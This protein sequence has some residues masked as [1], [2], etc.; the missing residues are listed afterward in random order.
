MIENSTHQNIDPSVTRVRHKRKPRNDT[1]VAMKKP[2]PVAEADIAGKPAPVVEKDIAKRP[3]PVAKANGTKSSQG[4]KNR[5]KKSLF[6]TIAL[7]LAVVFFV[8]AVVGAWFFWWTTQATFDYTLRP[9]VVLA[10][11][12][13]HPYDFM[14]EADYM[15]NISATYQMQSGTSS[16]LQ[17][18]SG[19]HEIPITLQLGLRSV[20]TTATLYVLEPIESIFHEFATKAEHMQPI[21]FIANAHI[22][23]G[24]GFDVTFTQT[25]L[26]LEHYSVGEHNLELALNG[27]PFQVKLFVEDTTPPTA[28]STSVTI[29]MGVTVVPE[30]FVS[31]IFDDSPITSIS[32]LEEPD[33]FLSGQQ[34]VEIEIT[35][36]FGNSEIF[37]STLTVESNEMP[38]RFEGIEPIIFSMV[39]QTIMYRTGVTAFDSFGREIDFNVDSSE[40]DQHTAGIYSAVFSAED[41]CGNRTEVTVTVE[42][43]SID[44]EYVHQRVDNILGNILTDGMTQVQQVRAIFNWIRFNMTYAAVRGG[45][46]SAYEGAFIALTQRRGNCFIYYSIGELLLTRAGIPNMRVQRI[47]VPGVTSTHLWSLIN[48]DDLGWHHFDS[49]PIRGNLHFRS[50]MYMFTQSQATSFA[51]QLAAVGSSLEYFT[52]DTSLFP[53]VVE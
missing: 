37:V 50:Q 39:G 36:Y 2:A 48:P 47:P 10:G 26:P 31:D 13:A 38:P 4:R 35:D 15:R 32:F 52:F 27:A 53:E 12:T 5:K 8:V 11:Q 42:I 28:T 46:E 45:P 20:D 29:P 16:N 34:N 41:C 14:A 44:R 23:T 51:R 9:V 6:S 3:T 21:E 22:A 43:L 18:E 7:T 19:R 24:I 1:T 40:V 25:P 30:E 49:N 17:F 33:V